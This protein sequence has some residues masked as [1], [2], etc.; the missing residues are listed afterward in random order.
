M[1][2][3]NYFAGVYIDINLRFFSGVYINITKEI[4]MKTIKL[5]KKQLK[6]L[7]HCLEEYNQFLCS[8][9][10]EQYIGV[11]K[12]VSF[13]AITPLGEGKKIS[14]Y[15]VSNDN[16]CE[17]GCLPGYDGEEP[18]GVDGQDPQHMSISCYKE[19]P[20][21]AAFLHGS[22][23]IWALVEGP[24]GSCTPELIFKA[25]FPQAG[26]ELATGF[27]PDYD[28]PLPDPCKLKSFGSINRTYSID[29]PDAD[30]DDCEY[31]SSINYSFKGN[32]V[33][34]GEYTWDC[35]VG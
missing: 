15:G 32:F 31:Y 2:I 16:Q 29:Y 25:Q 30:P 14:S 23:A 17:N 9:D 22:C 20:S 10:E 4:I 24:G 7:R 6:I 26:Q 8:I 28:G 1:K 18:A 19:E 13:A 11:C 33:E 3:N 12:I 5:T 21:P 35:Q 34:R 27:P